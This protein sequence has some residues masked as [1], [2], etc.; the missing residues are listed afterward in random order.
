VLVGVAVSAGLGV[1]A[2]GATLG[3]SVVKAVVGGAVGGAPLQAAI[4]VP[5]TRVMIKPKNFISKRRP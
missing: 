3:V 5:A 4:N 2:V 1:T